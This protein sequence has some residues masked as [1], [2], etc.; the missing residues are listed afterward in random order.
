MFA[1]QRHGTKGAVESQVVS[2][3]RIGCFAWTIR[4]STA[5]FSTA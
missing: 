5:R 1:Q 2:E 4:K 3:K